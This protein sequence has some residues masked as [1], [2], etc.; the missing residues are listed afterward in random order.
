M[1]CPNCGTNL[2]DGTAFCVKCGARL[3]PPAQPY[4]Q[5]Y[6]HPAPAQPY[7]QAPPAQPYNQAPPA[8]PY[9]QPYAQPAPAP[10]YAQPAP[11]QTCRN[12]AFPPLVG[13][14]NRVNDPAVLE[15][16]RKSNKA[17]GIFAVIIIPLPFI[18]FIIASFFS[19]ELSRLEAVI[20]GALVSLVFLVFYVV[21]AARKKTAKGW[22]GVV[23]EKYTTVKYGEDDEETFYIVKMRTD[24]GRTK[25]LKEKEFSH[26]YFD[27]LNIGDRVR[28][29]P[30]F[31][32]Y[33]E[34]YDKSR[35]GF[36]YCPM[37]ASK[38]GVELDY[39]PKCKLPV[40]K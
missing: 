4:N 5:A 28:Y 36:V 3:N 17:A 20:L 22:D 14:S 11:A 39:C 13:F 7:N 16:I 2:I 18:G 8:Q 33:Y 9:H 19:S 27:Y 15:A 1:I 29:H 24:D 40:I 10:A 6:A 34:K 23:T 30:Q 31:A 38:C 37:C 21:S 26:R 35:D 32:Y 12:P 25:K